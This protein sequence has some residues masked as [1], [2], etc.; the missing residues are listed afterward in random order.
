MSE[1]V[2]E[3]LYLE[4][5]ASYWPLLWG[6][7]FAVLGFL[8]EVLVGDRPHGLMWVFVGFGL[9]VL[10]SV[11]VYARRR[12]LTVR[13]TGEQLWQGQERQPIAQLA[14]LDDVGTPTG[15]RVLGGGW[16]VPRKYQELPLRLVDDSVVLA[17]ARDAEAL[18]TALRAAMRHCDT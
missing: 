3:P 15:T 9:L 13:V 6:P 5:G 10:T 11:W 8:F 14:E 1:R 16:S 4:R 7:V 12:F 2:S 17:W 18:R